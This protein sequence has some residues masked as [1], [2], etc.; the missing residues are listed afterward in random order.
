MT[1]LKLALLTWLS[2]LW[3]SQRMPG[4]D[5][6]TEFHARLFKRFFKLA[7]RRGPRWSRR[8][9]DAQ[10]SNSPVMG[11]VAFEPF[12]LGGVH[13]LTV[14]PTN[15]ELSTEQV[16]VYLHGGGYVTGSAQG[17]LPFLARIADQSGVQIYAPNYRLSPEHVYPAA[18]KD[19]YRVVAEIAKLHRQQQLLLMGDSTGGALCV[20]TALHAELDKP[21]D[22]LILISPWVEPTATVG[23]IFNNVPHDMFEPTFLASSY[24]AHL[25]G[26]DPFNQQTNF[27]RADLSHLPR[28][29]VQYAGGELFRDQIREF[30]E[31]AKRAGVNIKSQEFE[32]QFHVFQTIAHGFEDS[33]TARRQI[34][35]FLSDL[36]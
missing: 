21:V 28:T 14:T 31:R 11:R 5:W 2:M 26:A 13:G 7:D 34:I 32:H 15:R 24:Q 30:H 25:A 36:S 29:L 35:D 19:C 20:A 6:Q 22:A 23:S 33:K 16:L 4:R 8:V 18:Q 17:Y 1:M 12:S 10:K 27:V 3:S 9:I